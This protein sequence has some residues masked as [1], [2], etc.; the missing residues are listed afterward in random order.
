MA[1]DLLVLHLIKRPIQR[2]GTLLT[3]PNL[4]QNHTSVLLLRFNGSFDLIVVLPYLDH[5]VIVT[6]LRTR[7]IQTDL[8]LTRNADKIRENFMLRAHYSSV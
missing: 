2:Y 3:L 1:V 8:F 6:L 4:E 5:L 7:A